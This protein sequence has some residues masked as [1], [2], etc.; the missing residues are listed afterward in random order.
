MQRKGKC[1]ENKNTLRK[2]EKIASNS[3]IQPVCILLE[4]VILPLETGSI[5]PS[6]LDFF[7][8]NLFGVFFSE[9]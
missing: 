6:F 4:K 3:F 2:T 8:S 1:D 7:L 9:W 5:Y